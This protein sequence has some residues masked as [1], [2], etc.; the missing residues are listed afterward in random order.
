MFIV[1]CEKLCVRD[2]VYYGITGKSIFYGSLSSLSRIALPILNT[3]GLCSTII[4]LELGHVRSILGV[5]RSAFRKAEQCIDALDC[6]E[7]SDR[8]ASDFGF[9]FSL[10]VQKYFFEKFYISFH[11]IEL[12]LRYV[13]EK[14]DNNYV[15]LISSREAKKYYG[16]MLKSLFVVHYRPVFNFPRLLTSILIIPLVALVFSYLKRTRDNLSFDNKIICEVD[17]KITL[18]MFRNLFSNIPPQHLVFVTERRR[19]VDFDSFEHLYILGITNRGKR[20]IIWAAWLF[21]FR[22]LCHIRKVYQINSDLIWIYYIYICGRAGTIYGQGNIYCTFEHLV[23]VKAVRNELLRSSGNL[24]IFVPMNSYVTNQYFHSEFMLNYDVVL[25]PGRHFEDLYPNKRAKTQTYLS[26]GSYASHRML[27]RDNGWPDRNAALVDFK[28][29]DILILITSPGI[30]QPTL[31]IELELMALL[32]RLSQIHDVKIIL[33]LKPVE[34]LPIFKDFY[35][36]QLNGIEGIMVTADEYDLFD[37]VGVA[38]LVVTSISTSGYDLAQCGIT[39]MF[40]DYFD[41]ARDTEYL[42]NWLRDEGFPMSPNV[43]LD[44]IIAWI[45]NLDGSRLVWK[46][47]MKNFVN[48]FAYRHPS[49]E[50]YRQCVQNHLKE[51]SYKSGR[52]K[53]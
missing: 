36:K 12:A 51:L 25:S 22:A 33:R 32:R 48:Y 8:L 26:T 10:L 46:K 14:P 47:R 23:T 21:S 45:N 18:E 31:N 1:F 20:E 50:E 34:P 44:T 41:D 4:K 24:S 9:D 5:R 37:F 28:K 6:K 38:D 35:H 30:C 2:L 43:A 11:F 17:G 53:S 39:T 49:F 42:P 52:F 3:Y 27:M 15:I 40:I 19:L 7:W 29:N 13:D 16:K